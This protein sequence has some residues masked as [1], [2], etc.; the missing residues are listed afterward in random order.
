MRLFC[1]ACQGDLTPGPCTCAPSRPAVVIGR[2]WASVSRASERHVRVVVALEKLGVDEDC[3][4]R[5]SDRSAGV[6]S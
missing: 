4:I 2:Y 6:L 5:L 3:A 1:L